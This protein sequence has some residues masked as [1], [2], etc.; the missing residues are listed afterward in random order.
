MNKRIYLFLTIT[1]ALVLSTYTFGQNRFEGY[2]LTVEADNSGICPVR[3]LPSSGAGNA[4]D[5]YVAGTNQTVKAA[6]ITACG[7][8]V[9]QNGNKTITNGD[10]KWCFQGPE[11]MYEIKLTNGITYLWYPMDEGSGFYNLKDFR[12]VKRSTDGKYS[13]SEPPDYTRTFKNAMAFIAARQGGTL[14]VPDGDY[15]VG[16]TDG[17][18]RDPNYQ[19]ITLPSGINIVGAGANISIPN[20][21]LP[22]RVSPTRIRLRNPDQTIFRIGGCTNRVM[23][24]NLELV[25]NASLVSE[26]VRNMNNTYG[27]EGLGKWAKDARGES[28]NSSQIFKFENIT[29][30]DLD[31]GIYV[32]NINDDNCKPAEQVCKSWQFDYVKIDHA[33]FLNN[34]TGIFVDTG[35]T[36]WTIANSVFNYIAANA[37]GDGIHL[38]NAGTML[39]QQTFGGGYDYGSGIGGTFLYVD[40]V[41]SLTVINSSSERGQRSIYTNP[42][43]MISNVMLIMTGDVFADKVELRGLV[44]FISSGNFFGANTI[45]ADPTAVITSTGDR[46]CYDARLVACTD[47]SGKVVSSPNS[48][49]GRMMFQTGRLP[50]GSGQT[51]IDGRPNLFGYNVEVRDGLIQY[52][53]NTTFSDITKWA[54]GGDGRPPVR[55]GAYVYCKDCRRG[56]VCSQGQAGSDGAFAKRINGRWMC[57]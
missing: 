30:Q 24:S 42:L 25:G 27:I 56:G 41:G 35:N 17:N 34:K 10:G 31:K 14:R 12:P 52:D 21:N 48:N 54:Q 3:Y 29:F 51:R 8:S 49:G 22:S 46:F 7:G 13:F 15:I 44:N 6:G 11:P 38:K 32:H 36:D 45:L 33:L 9:V 2:S 53:P 55:D 39:I 40:T 50:E 4:V 37:P 26:P 57:D 18:T 28:A 16:T 1:L 47:S 5:V 43:G 20:T 19:A 23:I